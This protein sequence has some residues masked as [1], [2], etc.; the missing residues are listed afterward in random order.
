MNHIYQPYMPM[1]AVAPGDS[2]LINDDYAELVLHDL[3]GTPDQPIHIHPATLTPRRL[4]RLIIHDS[5][6][7]VRVDG[8]HNLIICPFEPTPEAKELPLVQVGGMENTVKHC[9]IQTIN[10]PW[11]WQ[12]EDWH[13]LARDGIQLHGQDNAAIGNLIRHVRHGVEA[14]GEGSA[15]LGNI[16]RDYCGDGIRLLNHDIE[17]AYNV[18]GYARL[19]NPDEHRDNMQAWQH[20]ALSPVD[21]CLRGLRIHHNGFYNP[22]EYPTAQG[23]LC[24]DGVLKGCEISYN[25]IITNHHHG[26]T[27]ASAQGCTIIGNLI[28]HSGAGQSA[29]LMLGTRKPNHAVCSGNQLLDNRAQRYELP[30]DACTPDSDPQAHPDDTI[31]RW[32]VQDCKIALAGLPS[33]L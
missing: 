26:L 18:G 3:Q 30:P 8:L 6:Q 27:I 24:F 9:L 16:Y 13:A 33:W 29:W 12:A 23:G 2:L 14:F 11:R 17:A 5:C 1:H 20:T 7:H 32:A 15:I 21:G 4:G 31:I 28:A 22:P 19:G 25:T 10:D